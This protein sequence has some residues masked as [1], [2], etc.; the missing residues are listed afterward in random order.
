MNDDDK[1]PIVYAIRRLI[2]MVILVWVI[3]TLWQVFLY[4]VL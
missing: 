1:P 4:F 3:W 2:A